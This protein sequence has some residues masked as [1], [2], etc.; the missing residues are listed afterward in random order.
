MVGKLGKQVAMIP[1]RET[2]QAVDD[3][4]TVK[5]AKYTRFFWPILR[6]LVVIVAAWGFIAFLSVDVYGGK[7]GFTAF[8]VFTLATLALRVMPFEPA[9]SPAIED[10]RKMKAKHRLPEWSLLAYFV[11]FGLGCNWE[12][13]FLW[14]S[15]RYDLFS[16]PVVGATVLIMAL[17]AAVAILVACLTTKNWRTALVVFAF[18]PGV[19]AA[20]VLRLRLLR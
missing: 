17:Y 13:V 12:C 4:G 18:A 7:L 5:N 14:F 19:L 3:Q 16:A 15:R 1:T 8:T 9:T 2:L 10:E 20:I 11:I 6:G